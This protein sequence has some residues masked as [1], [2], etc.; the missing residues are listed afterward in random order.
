[1]PDPTCRTVLLTEDNEQV[2]T[3][4]TAMLEGLGYDVVA[5]SDGEEALTV[6]AGDRHFDLLFTD[7][8]MPG[9][10]S[11]WDLAREARRRHPDL[12]TLFTSGYSEESLDGDVDI[13]ALGY[14]LKKP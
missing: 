2:C 1:V 7:I 9:G 3:V 14:L 5:A 8:V 4:I 11:G 12:R 10:M 13:T 6:L